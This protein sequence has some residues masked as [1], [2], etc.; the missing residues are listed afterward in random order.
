MGTDGLPFSV[1]WRIHDAQ[2]WGVPQRRQR[3]AVVADFNGLTA[4]DIMFNPQLRRETFG[5]ESYEVE[6]GPGGE[7]GREVQPVGTG[8]CGNSAE[9]GEEGEATAGATE[10]GASAYTLKIRGGA[11]RDSSGRLAGKG[12][13]I[14]TELSAT[15]GV[16]QDQTLI[17]PDDGVTIPIHD[18]AT[19]HAGK[20]GD[21]HD[22]KGNGLGIGSPEDPSPTIS[23]GDHHAV[24][25]SD[26]DRQNNSCQLN[27]YEQH[28]QDSRYNPL[29]EVG[30][31]VSAKY[32]TG[33][34]NTPIVIG[35]KQ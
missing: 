35:R 22:G 9:S 15:L 16:S 4:A 20:H 32:G 18:Q 31:T 25:R 34:N 3:I 30:E 11:E 1:A 17:K 27:L 13:L 21:K 28:S 24:F 5:T 23:S 2:W 19:R 14:Q 12:A 26:I 33:G 7:C 29:G 6:R 10:D 8:L